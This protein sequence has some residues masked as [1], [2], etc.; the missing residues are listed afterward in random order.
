MVIQAN[1]VHQFEGIQALIF[2][3][4]FANN[5]LEYLG[6]DCSFYILF[7]AEKGLEN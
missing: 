5:A 6:I 2:K 3:R 7:L 1:N 4:Q